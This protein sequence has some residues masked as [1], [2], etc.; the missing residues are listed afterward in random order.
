MKM[1]PLGSGDLRIWMTDTELSRWG[2]SLDDMRQGT[3]TADRAVRRLLGVARQ[4]LVF[5]ADGQIQ[6]EVL[7]ISDGCVFLFTADRPRPPATTALPQI[8]HIASAEELLQLGQVLAA[9]PGASLPAASLYRSGEGYY[10]IVY[11]GLG[12]IT[13]YRRLL[14][15]F[16]TCVGE[17][18]A[19]ASFI[20]EHTEAVTVG[21]ALY[22]LLTAYGSRLPTPPHPAR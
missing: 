7:P 2:L 14:H 16:G 13:G 3:P 19:A 20:A 5:H 22:Q 21:E 11:A 18:H 12:P 8:Y 15:E 4:R 9:T 1:E 17:G 6:V 10:L